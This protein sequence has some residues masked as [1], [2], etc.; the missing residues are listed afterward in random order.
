ML[1]LLGACGDAAQP[2]ATNTSDTPPSTATPPRPAPLPTYWPTEQ[3]RLS[4]PEEQGVDSGRLLQALTYVDETN[5]NLRSLTVIRNGY[6][7]LDAY[8]QPF[9]QD[10]LYPVASVT[11]SVIGAL[12]G[13]AIEEGKIESVH[14]PLLSFFPEVVL[15]HRD[16]RKEAI[17]IE[18][19]LT[20][21]PGLDCA[22]DVLNFGMER[23]S[24]WVQYVFDLP[25]ATDPGQELVYCTAGTHLLSALLTKATGM[26]A[27]EYAQLRLFDPLGISRSAYKWG[28]DPQGITLGGYGL[29]MHPHDMARLG[30]LY[31][32]NGKW[33]DRQVVPHSWVA[34]S[35]TVHAYGTDPKHYGYL[36]WVYPTHFAA[37]GYGE[38]KIQVVRDHNMVV[39]MT[40]AID[41]KQGAPLEKLLK[42][43]IIPAATSVAPL[44]PNETAFT[45][46]KARVERLANPA[47]AVPPLP[48]IAKLISG[49]SYVMEK[50][51]AGVEIITLV[52]EE[53]KAEAY[54]SVTSAGQEVKAELGLDNLYRITK[55][56]SSDSVIAL[57]GR[58]EDGTTFLVRRLN[59]DTVDEEE[60]RLVFEGSHLQAHVEERVFG[61]YSFDLKGEA[62]P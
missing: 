42:E 16:P 37:E 49:K 41:W 25:M 38:Q 15:T 35:T 30:L 44:P 10:N 27:Q 1:N 48:N 14:Q 19:L 59:F 54:A 50:N 7:V 57:V 39:V 40:A 8:Y 4:T 20:M 9:T 29:Q 36:F 17:T 26:P 28:S 18:D 2:P 55:N 11:K 56:P 61:R 58:W 43:Y 33:G 13:I 23:S 31:L 6:I 62:K 60:W 5:V 12:V 45:Q 47:E 21:Q 24:N 53:G 34:A 52:F 51:E 32:N 46:L 3:W 22:D